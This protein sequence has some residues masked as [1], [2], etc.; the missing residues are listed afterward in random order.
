MSK[1][2]WAFRQRDLT[3]ALKAAI[4]AGLSPTSATI[5]R[6]GNLTVGF[7]GAPPAALESWDKVIDLWDIERSRPA[8]KHRT[9]T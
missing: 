2:P 1:G 3:R 6:H 9:A 5:D 8:R 4:A 7:S